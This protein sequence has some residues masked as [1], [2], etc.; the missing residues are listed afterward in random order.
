MVPSAAKA[1]VGIKI[2]GR[3]LVG[4]LASMRQTEVFLS[5]SALVV[6]AAFVERRP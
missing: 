6:L 1:F 5:I 4:L 3:N 2:L